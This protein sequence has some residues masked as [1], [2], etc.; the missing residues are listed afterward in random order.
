MR[1]RIIGP[2]LFVAAAFLSL[3]ALMVGAPQLFY[4][5]I[6]VIATIL[7]GKLLAWLSV[8]QLR[9]ERVAPSVAHVGELVT[10]ET[11][12]WSNLR[13]RRLLVSIQDHL[14]SKMALAT[15]SPSLP[16][17]PAFDRPTRS[18]YRFRPM[19]RGRFEWK[20]VT[21]FG[22]D[23]LGLSSVRK[24]Y[25]TDQTELLVVP[26][27]IPMTLDRPTSAGIGISEAGSGQARGGLEPRGIREFTPGDS[28]RHIHWRSTAKTGHLLVKEFEAGAQARV[29]I[30]IQRSKGSES[31]N[32][33]M[34][35]LDLMCGNA[36]FLAQDLARSGAETALPQF[37]DGAS[38]QRGHNR[39][40]QI[41]SILAG[42]ESTSAIEIAHELLAAQ[43]NPENG[44]VFY[45]FVGISDPQLP[46]AVTTVINSGIPV[47]VLIYD[48]AGFGRRV[49]SDRSAADPAFI[50]SL[51]AAG[52]RT[53]IVPVSGHGGTSGA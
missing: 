25:P 39:A 9:I 26:T 47:T 53:V 44:D 4:M 31:G 19:R 5:S 36:L 22:L 43:S 18:Q 29:G 15:V 49:R 17:A 46:E 23:A 30:L 21:I 48:P 27:P 40:L 16:I 20:G 3:V 37:E 13:I 24:F 50:D 11:V 28:L 8:Q 33:P 38:R 2:G 52:A 6:A 1:R 51:A 7:C 45:V 10:I 34:T 14:P 42:I 35:S 41:E 12:V 32:P